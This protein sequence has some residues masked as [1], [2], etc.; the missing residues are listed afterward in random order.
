[1]H[2]DDYLRLCAEKGGSDLH[3]KAD[4][5]AHVRID[6]QL[7]EVH[8]LPPLTGDDT[9]GF[10]ASIMDTA[11]RE[12]LAAGSEADFAYSLPGVARFRAAVFHQRGSIGWS[13]VAS[14]WG[15]RASLSSGCR[16]P[17]ASSPRS[18]AGWSW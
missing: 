8:D 11:A 6:G 2:I 16:P 17:S 12:R 7:S 4:G 18:T 3:L 9:A 13:C 15:A 5:P 10:A 14:P 1:M